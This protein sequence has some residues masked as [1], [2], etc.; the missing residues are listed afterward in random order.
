[1]PYQLYGNVTVDGL[2]AQA[3]IDIGA[4]I[5]GTLFASTTT[6]SAG[7]YGYDPEFFRIP[8]DDPDTPAKEGGVNGEQVEI[9]V[10]G[11][12]AATTAFYSGIINNLNLSVTSNT[13]PAIPEAPTGL[14]A[15]ALASGFVLLKWADNSS[16]EEGFRISRSTDGSSFN[17]I[18]TV[19][20]NVKQYIDD[21][22]SGG[23]HYYYVV[24]A[25]NSTGDSGLAGPVD[26]TTQNITTT[27]P[28]TTTTTPVPTTT[29]TPPTTTSPNTQP[30]PTT[31]ATPTTT[32]VA[33]NPTTTTSSPPTSG[34][35]NAPAST[36]PVYYSGT[37]LSPPPSVPSLPVSGNTTVATQ[38]VT[39][40]TEPAIIDST[41]GPTTLNITRDEPGS[42][43]S[44]YLIIGG[45][46]AALILVALLSFYLGSRRS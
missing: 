2:T 18:T 30:N 40:S 45:A 6:D 24:T 35:T 17:A 37:L 19:G 23:T 31:S 14:S 44:I 26:V 43:F 20:S 36:P 21:S 32:I 12:A 28:P 33:P 42:S 7:R 29:T 22:V 34:S 38:S 11:I 46:V 41:T 4:Y 8:A 13:P 3:G 10:S 27:T 1:M 15:T 39:T 5:G 16:T 25:F 9:R